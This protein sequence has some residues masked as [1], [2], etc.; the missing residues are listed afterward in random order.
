M[1][2]TMTNLRLTASALALAAGLAF[3]LPASAITVSADEVQIL[4]FKSPVKTVFVGNPTI[5]DVTVID[6]THVFV[7]GKSFG[8]TNLVTL[9]EEGHQGASERITVL[10]RQESIVTLQRGTAR[11]TLYCAANRCEI[12]PTPGDDAE[13]FDAVAGQIDK[14]EAQNL[15]SATTGP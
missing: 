7:L 8:M 6:S 10:N 11:S 14:R 13:R 12:S 9:D 2:R 1:E 5:A 3:V 15:K 4:T